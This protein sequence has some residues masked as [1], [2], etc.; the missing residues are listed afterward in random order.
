[1]AENGSWFYAVYLFGV[2][3]QRYNEKISKV[4]I[5]A[6][7]VQGELLTG[8]PSPL[9][10]GGQPY[11]TINIYNHTVVGQDGKIYKG[12]HQDKLPDIL[13]LQEPSSLTDPSPSITQVPLLSTDPTAAITKSPS[14]WTHHKNMT[15]K[16]KQIP[17]SLNAH[18][19]SLIVVIF[20]LIR[21]L[22]MVCVQ[23][24]KLNLLVCRGYCGNGTDNNNTIGNILC[25]FAL[26]L[27]SPTH[28]SC[29]I[30]KQSY[31]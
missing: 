14:M 12:V 28:N 30:T 17:C 25:C 1:M 8:R 11:P 3:K 24:N 16:Y 10:T 19:Q 27:S 7:Q 5:L 18:F 29:S 13:N 15:W 31:T 21:Q 23:W 4:V 9:P 22:V 26:L 6:F 20:E 2:M